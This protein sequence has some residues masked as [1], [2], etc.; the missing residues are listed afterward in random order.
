MGQLSSSKNQTE[1][2][3]VDTEKYTKTQYQGVMMIN[4]VEIYIKNSAN[5][6]CQLAVKASE[7]QI[8]IGQPSYKDFVR[9]VADSFQTVQSQR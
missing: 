8:K 5:S 6:D 9:I 4:M 2:S 7:L 1:D 3:T